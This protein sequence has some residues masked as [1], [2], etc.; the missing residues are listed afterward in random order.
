MEPHLLQLLGLLALQQR[1]A[2]L[3]PRFSQP[4]PHLLRLL[5]DSEER[6][7]EGIE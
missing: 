6:E 3:G 7:E 4:F 1:V 2:Q 5:E